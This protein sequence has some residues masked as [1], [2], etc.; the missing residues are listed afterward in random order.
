MP[1]SNFSHHGLLGLQYE[2]PNLVELPAYSS[3][4]TTQT[5]T[6]P[7]PDYMLYISINPGAPLGGSVGQYFPGTFNGTHFKAVDSVARIADF[8]KDNY[9]SQ[10]FSGLPASEPQV[11][12]G[13]ASNWQ[14][15]SDVPTGDTEGWRSQMS[16]PR[17]NYLKEA[18]TIG[19]VLVSEPYNIQS[20]FE[21]ELAFN[22]SLANSSILIDYS[23]LESGALYF[24]ANITG[25]ST[26]DLS[27]TPRSPGSSSGVAPPWVQIPGSTAATPTL[28]PRTLTSRTSSAPRVSMAAKAC[29]GSVAWLIGRSLRCLLMV[30]IPMSK[31][32]PTLKTVV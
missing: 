8:G 14:Y 25:L 5:E 22:N 21:S 31:R 29:G 9:A 1:Q 19:W 6:V 24:E 26:S 30:R 4:A 13:W 7:K 11:S 2:C 27:G 10:F 16:V 18:P 3:S 32:L 12:F 23:T 15:C 20:V 17:Y 28:S